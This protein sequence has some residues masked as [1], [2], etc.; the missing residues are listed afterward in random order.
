MGRGGKKNHQGEQILQELINFF[1]FFVFCFRRDNINKTD[2]QSTGEIFLFV[3]NTKKFK[4]KIP[5]GKE[6]DKNCDNTTK[7]NGMNLMNFFFL[8]VQVKTK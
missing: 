3:S 1:F 6:N 8:N 5:S 7:T 4:R 2:E